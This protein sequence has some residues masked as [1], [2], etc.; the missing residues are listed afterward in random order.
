VLLSGTGE[1]GSRTTE[2]RTSIE[3]HARWK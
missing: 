2:E 3:K 1:E